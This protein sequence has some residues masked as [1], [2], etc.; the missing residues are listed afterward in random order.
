M[1]NPELKVRGARLATGAE[2]APDTSSLV[3]DSR[4]Q[5]SDDGIIEPPNLTAG[6]TPRWSH[7]VDFRLKQ[8]FVGIHITD[9]GKN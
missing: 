4:L 7:G 1:G 9:A 3:A 5:H 8:G 6:E 2:V